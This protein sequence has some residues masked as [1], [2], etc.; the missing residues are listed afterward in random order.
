LL[1]IREI[2]G[3]TGPEMCLASSKFFALKLLG[4]VVESRRLN[5]FLNSPWA[6]ATH[7]NVDGTRVKYSDDELKEL[8]GCRDHGIRNIP[9]FNREVLPDVVSN[10]DAGVARRGNEYATVEFASFY[11]KPEFADKLLSANVPLVVAA[12]LGSQSGS[13]DHFI[14]IV[15][16]TDD[17]IWAVDPWHGVASRAVVQLDARMSFTKP[18]TKLMAY[19]LSYT[20]IPCNPPWFGYYRDLDQAGGVKAF[21][22]SLA[23]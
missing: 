23:L 5:D 12:T 11:N 3:I 20:T 7:E 17:S 13:C 10:L 16:A 8:W 21:P 4:F 19:E 1:K 15:R 18:V 14:V 2:E 6:K 9:R 22:L